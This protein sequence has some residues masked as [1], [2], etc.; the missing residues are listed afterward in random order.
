MSDDLYEFVNSNRSVDRV[1]DRNTYPENQPKDKQYSSNLDGA[2]NP[3]TV[4]HYQEHIFAE[5]FNEPTGLLSVYDPTNPDRQLF[6][7]VETEVLSLTSPPIKYYKLIPLANNIDSLY[8]EARRRDGYANPVIIYGLYD[9]PSP[10]QELMQWGLTNTEDIELWF[11]YHHLL[12][13]IGDKLQIGDVLQTYDA[14]LWEVM[15][16]IIQDENLWRAQHNM[17]RAKRM[18]TEGIFLPDKGN[19]SSSPNIP[20]ISATTPKVPDR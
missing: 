13:T 18:Q 16:S 14:K 12:K 9:D 17:V 1:K 19:I 20:R 5:Q 8:G 6:D 2:V 11:N 3:Q 15:T 4:D 10:T 7:I